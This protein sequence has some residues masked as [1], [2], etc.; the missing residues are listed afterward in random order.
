MAVVED[1]IVGPIGLLDLVEGLGDEEA[2]DAVAGHE[3]EGRLEEVQP[4]QSGEL[5]EH[6]QDAMAPV[7]GLKVLRQAP[8]DL[9]QDEPDEGLGPADVAGWD[10]Q[11]EGDR[12]FVGDEVGNPPVTAPR[13]LGDHRVAV[14]AEEAHGR[15]EH[16]RAFI[17]RLVQQLPRGRGDDGM[18]PR[19]AE[20][21][22]GHHRPE[23]SLDGSA[24]IGEEGR[25][26]GEGLVLLG[27][28]HM[29]DRPDQERVACLLPVV[30]LVQGAFRVD[31]H[32]GDV[33]HVAHFPF[34][35]ADLQ[36]GIIGRGGG[37]GGIKQQDAAVPGPE[38]GGE[39]PV[40]A[41]DVVDDAAPGPGQE[42]GHDEADALAAPR[43]GE[44]QH[45]LGAIMAQ[46]VPAKPAEHHAVGTNE[47]R[48]LHLVRLGPACRAIGGD[49]L[50]LACP[51]HRHGDRGGD[52]D[53]AAGRGN[54]RAPAEDAGGIGVIGEPPGEESRR[55]VD[56]HAG[57]LEPRRPQ[58]G[59]EA[60][61]PGDVLGRAPGRGEHD[62][63]NDDDLAPED[64]G[65]GHESAPL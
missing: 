36:Q 60:E 24:R 56:R 31:Q 41:L 38:A 52:G 10:D 9:V 11:I 37:I 4:P 2:L 32:V 22:S 64:L 6:H 51:P 29:Q 17:V 26:P 12:A 58:L 59:L 23:R 13:D 1:G 3:S 46:I 20:M 15:A 28:E 21:R 7:F 50:G 27:V 55:E 61:L 43:R 40:L 49:G 25:H 19:L 47:A 16:A 30:P 48:R 8:A 53:E 63:A 35:L 33:L 39:L 45:V 42:R 34:A 14:E 54:E 57:E 18:R 5:V 44:A 62:Q 65:G